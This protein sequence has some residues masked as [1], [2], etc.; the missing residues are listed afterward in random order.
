MRRVAQIVSWIALIGA[1]A[2]ACLFFVDRCT[3][4]QVKQWTLVA[5]IVWFIATPFWMDRAK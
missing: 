5:T 3:L 1:L 2:P 4:E